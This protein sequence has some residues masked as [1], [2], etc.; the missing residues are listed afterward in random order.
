M[1]ICFACFSGTLAEA[2]DVKASFLVFGET[3]VVNESTG[4]PCNT[5][6]L[7]HDEKTSIKRRAAKYRE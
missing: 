3:F 6:E 2:L 5:V 1:S 7:C 4:A